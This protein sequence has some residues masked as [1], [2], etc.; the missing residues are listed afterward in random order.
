VAAKHISQRT[1]IWYRQRAELAEATLERQRNRW[2]SDWTLGWIN[3][4]TIEVSDAALARVTT[5]RL[6]KHAVI[7]VPVDGNKINFYAEQI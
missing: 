7:A 4:A 3:I 2:A 1:A 5:A 6:L